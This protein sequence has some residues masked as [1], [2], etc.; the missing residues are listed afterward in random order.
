MCKSGNSR[1]RQ[2]PRLNVTSIEKIH[3]YVSRMIKRILLLCSLLLP[4]ATIAPAQSGGG[5]PDDVMH[6][7]VLPGWRTSDGTHMAALHIQLQPGWK[8]YWRAPGAGGIPPQFD[9]SGSRNIKSVKFYWPRPKVS[10]I[11]GLRTISYSDEVI[12][13]VEF[14]PGKSGQTLSLEGRVDLGVCNDI[15]I[16]Y[17]LS[18]AAVLSAEN[19]KPDQLIRTALTKQP[20][21]ASQ[22]GV[23]NATCAI[24]PIKDGLRVTATITLPSTG[25]GEITVIE[26]PDQSIWVAEAT[27]TRRGNTLTAITEMVPPSNAPFVLDRS[28][29]RITVMG[30]KR[31]VDILGCTG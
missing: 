20:T 25:S 16:P 31:A 23:K 22:A 1:Y 11:S 13:P 27:T 26:A 8:T 15:C 10:Y 18:F 6:M 7:T 9:W 17:S 29:I 12:I 14:T 24:E 3:A 19:T 30:S 4:A 2:T 28:K 21:P 5:V